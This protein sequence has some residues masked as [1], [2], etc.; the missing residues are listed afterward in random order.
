MTTAAA[1]PELEQQEE[2][3]EGEE[4]P[5]PAASAA[6]CLPRDWRNFCEQ[7][8]QRALT[9]WWCAAVLGMS[10]VALHWG[11]VRIETKCMCSER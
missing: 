10:G 4:V 6:M 5:A 3:G 1:V 2:E 8:V 9:T 7:V 11:M